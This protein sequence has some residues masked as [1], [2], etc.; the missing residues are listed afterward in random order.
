MRF[1]YRIYLDRI[2][3]VT[4]HIGNV[5]TYY[6]EL[7]DNMN[8]INPFCTKLSFHCKK[9]ESFQLRNSYYSNL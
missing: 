5:I 3:C 8:N 9:F 2:K 4:A 7:L 6:D 1:L